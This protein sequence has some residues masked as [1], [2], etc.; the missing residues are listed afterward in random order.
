[1]EIYKR[2]IKGSVFYMDKEEILEL[3][4][5][6]M[7]QIRLENE[8]SLDKMAELLGMSKRMLIHIEKGKTHVLWIHTIGICALFPDSSILMSLIG[9]DPLQTI[10]MLSYEKPYR[11]KNKTYG[12]RIWWKDVKT[13]GNYSLQ[14]NMISQHFRI[15]DDEQ[16]RWYS[17][18][19]EQE[20]T[21]KLIE[22]YKEDS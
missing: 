7:K 18:F 9:E 20:A 1:M 4:S 22:L 6:N 14:Q 8:L 12:G 2:K 11:P 5:E 13:L 16:D 21:L 19:D 15:V 3:I 10:Q 17:T